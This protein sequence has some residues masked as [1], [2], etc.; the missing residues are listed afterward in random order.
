[1]ATFQ[2]RG[3]RWRAIVRIRGAAQSKSF[4]TKALAQTWAKR[5]E[6]EIEAGEATGRRHSAKTV[7]DVIDWYMAEV[8]KTARWQRSKEASLK[9]LRNMEWSAKA[10]T[11]LKTA[12]M[13][14]FARIRREE[15]AG[16]ST[17]NQDVIFLNVAFKAARAIGVYI[18]LQAISDAA[19]DLRHR[20]A[21]GRGDRRQRRPTDDEL[22]RLRE[23]FR[24]NAPSVP[25]ADIIDFAILT[26]RRQSEITRIRW[27]DVDRDNGIAWVNDVKHPT[28]KIGNRKAF[29]LLPAA[30]AIIDR[31]PKSGVLVFP[32]SAKYVCKLFTEACAFLGIDNLHFHDLRHHGTSLLFEAGYS[33]QEV[34]LFTLHDSWAMLQRYT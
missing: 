10:A 15:G 25:M 17:I 6:A 19:I 32:Y 27:S 1:M 30:L 4:P 3:E 23:Y 33:I 28:R 2:K 12:D 18:D 8:G 22:N 29:R 26:T 24:S 16:P 34:A 21:I 13:L 14:D 20:K 5:I 7:R 9:R 11:K 31:Q